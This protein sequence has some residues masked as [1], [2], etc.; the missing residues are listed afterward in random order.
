MRVMKDVQFLTQSTPLIDNTAAKRV[1]V[2]V[3]SKII[4]D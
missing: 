2:R 1:F 4:N 3:M